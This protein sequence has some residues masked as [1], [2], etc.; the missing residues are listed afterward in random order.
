MLLLLR[1]VSL[2]DDINDGDIAVGGGV[3]EPAPAPTFCVVWLFD[4]VVLF[5]L[6][7]ES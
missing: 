3:G 6:T 5:E 7:V 4:V 1:Q 2:P